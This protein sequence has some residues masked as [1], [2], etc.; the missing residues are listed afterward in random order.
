MH[1][2][3]IVSVPVPVIV[4]VVVVVTTF[5]AFAPVLSVATQIG[6]VANVA[7]NVRAG[8]QLVPNTQ[9]PAWSVFADV[10]V[11]MPLGM[12]TVLSLFRT[13]EPLAAA[14]LK[15]TGN[16]VPPLLRPNLKLSGVALEMRN[17]TSPLLPPL[18]TA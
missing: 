14:A 13:S 10:P 15:E 8:P 18:V 5:V 11:L 4:K 12:V 16:A 1:T 6:A 17:L 9:E 3:V 2:Y 7:V